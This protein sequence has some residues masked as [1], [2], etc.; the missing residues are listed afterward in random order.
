M[1]LVG[2]I[3]TVL[4][5]LMSVVFMSFAVMV[6]AT[7]QNWMDQV[8]NPTT[9]YD[10]RLKNKTAELANAKLEHARTTQ[11]LALEQASRR[12]ALAALQTRLTQAEDQVTQQ[13][14]ELSDKTRDLQTAQEGF[15]VAQ[16]RL[17]GLEAENAKLRK[18]TQLAQLDRDTQFSKV[19]ELTDRLNQDEVKRQA[20]EER[21]NQLNAQLA[22]MKMV[23]DAHGLKPDSLVSSLEPINLNGIV[24]VVGDKD[25]VEISVGKDDGLREGHIMEVYRGDTY[26]GQIKIMKVAPDRAVG[27]INKDL[28]R[29]QVRKGDHVTTKFS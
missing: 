19:V 3:F 9:G 6:F 26:I 10:V 29:G 15:R 13:T 7:H 4:I 22:Q 2:K 23:M 16:D 1:T 18:E 14:K 20:L 12:Q 24:L 27:Q 17:V 11:Q 28:K 8:K 21:S 5:L 25:L